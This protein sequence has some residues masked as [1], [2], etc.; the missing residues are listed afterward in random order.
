MATFSNAGN[1]CYR[2]LIARFNNGAK[3]KCHE[4]LMENRF[5]LFNR[6]IKHQ[7]SIAKIKLDSLKDETDACYT[8]Q[9]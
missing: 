4:P 8:L 5:A 1:I 9:K 2:K 7:P 3:L 6:N